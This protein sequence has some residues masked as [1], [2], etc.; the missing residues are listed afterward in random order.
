MRHNSRSRTRLFANSSPAVSGIVDIG[1]PIFVARCGITGPPMLLVHGLGSSHAHWLAVT[2]KFARHHQVLAPD[3]PGFG[4]SPLE[5]RDTGVEANAKLISRLVDELQEPVILVGHSLGALVTMLVAAD[6]PSDIAGLVLVAPLAPRPWRAPLLQWNALLFSV[7]SWPVVGEW[8]RRQW[9]R[10]H[11]PQGMVR[12]VFEECCTVPAA[13]PRDVREAALAVADERWSHDDDVHAFLSAYRSALPY[14][15][16]GSRFDR[17]VRRISTPT[18]II[19]GADDRLVP[20]T[21]V[22]R[23]CR[24]RPDW[25][26]AMLDG[27]G[28]MPHVEDASAFVRLV[29]AWHHDEPGAATSSRRQWRPAVA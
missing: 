26:L 28:H 7:Y 1:G 4:R 27:I 21:A 13:V 5:A 29:N 3:L 17:L 8:T 11:G 23:C 2:R 19:H 18:L 25:T 6:R 16:S 24:L 15:L 9:V 14:L 20:A 22:R 10:L 12:S